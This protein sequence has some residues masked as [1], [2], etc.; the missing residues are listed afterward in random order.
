MTFLSLVSFPDRDP[1]AVLSHVVGGGGGVQGGRAGMGVRDT[2]TTST[3]TRVGRPFGTTPL[4]G[5][6]GGPQRTVSSHRVS[7]LRKS[8]TCVHSGDRAEVVAV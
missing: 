6:R 4:S 1:D 3:L 5:G 8:P 7:V 2:S